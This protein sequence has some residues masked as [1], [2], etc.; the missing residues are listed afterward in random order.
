MIGVW[1]R[2][3][4]VCFLPLCSLARID[5]TCRCTHFSKVGSE[6]LALLARVCPRLRR[7]SISKSYAVTDSALEALGVAAA[8]AA[9]A[10]GGIGSSGAGAAGCGIQELL[11]RQ[12]PRVSL[13]GLLGRCRALTSLDLSGCPRVS[14]AVERWAEWRGKRE[15][16]G[17]RYKVES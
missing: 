15:R 3:D 12:C 10:A 7:L 9:V 11:L 5:C 13:V 8:A 2:A 4:F 6:S 14:R 1:G 17:A 16:V